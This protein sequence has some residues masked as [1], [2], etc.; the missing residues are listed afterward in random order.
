MKKLLLLHNRHTPDDSDIWRVAIRRGWATYRTNEF[1][2]KD[3]MKGYDFI[4]YYGNTLH[5][6]QIKNQLPFHFTPIRPNI[7]SDAFSWTKRDIQLKR[8]KDIIQPITYDCFIK[9]VSEKWFEARAYKKGEI[10]PGAANDNDLCYVS[11]IEEFIDEVR[12]FCLYGQIMTSSLYRINKISYQEVESPESSNFDGHL[13]N[14]P[15]R[16]YTADLEGFFDL[17]PGVVMDFGRT[18]DNIWKLIEFNEAWASGL[19][20][21]DPEKC[22]DVIIESQQNKSKY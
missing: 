2:V 15:L 16:G 9:P 18:K 6:V 12:C 11:D 3:H 8:F 17:P 21:C 10:I 5:A 22:L 13:D 19:Y 14:T 7:L 1:E 20:F 4:R